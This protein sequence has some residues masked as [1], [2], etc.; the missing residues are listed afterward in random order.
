MLLGHFKPFYYAVNREAKTPRDKA[1]A[2]SGSNANNTYLKKFVK[3]LIINH[4]CHLELKT[5]KTKRPTK[6]PRRNTPTNPSAI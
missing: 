2:K 1:D 4:V 6:Q 3:N 5:R